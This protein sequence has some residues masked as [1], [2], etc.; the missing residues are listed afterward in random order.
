M[1]SVQSPPFPSPPQAGAVPPVRGPRRLRLSNLTPHRIAVERTDGGP[2]LVLPPFGCRTLEFREL[3]A[4]AVG[5]WTARGLAAVEPHHRARPAFGFAGLLLLGAVIT[6]PVAVL[7]RAYT[8]AYVWV[9]LVLLS[10]AVLLATRR[11]W[12]SVRDVGKQG[13]DWF[14]GTASLLVVCAVGFGL[15]LALLSRELEIDK[16]LAGKA[17][18]AV[19]L[20]LFIGVVSTVPALLYF[21]F[22]QQQVRALRERFF[23]EVIRLDP[24]LETLDDAR[25]LHGPLAD[26]TYGR[27][28]GA[29]LFRPS[30][31]PVLISTFLITL[32]WC[33][34]LSSAIKALHDNRSAAPA[35]AQATEQVDE[36]DQAQATDKDNQD[37]DQDTTGGTTFLNL[38]PTQAMPTFAFLGAYFFALN[39]LFRRY[40]RGDLG[41]KAYSHI[42]ARIV[43][44]VVLALVMSVVPLTPGQKPYGLIL[45]FLVGIFP[46]KGTPALQRVL[47]GWGPVGALF[48][49]RREEEDSLARLDGITQYDRSRLLEEGIENVENLAH[50]NLMELM[51]RTRIPTARLV[52]L[53][54]QAVLFLHVRDP[55]PAAPDAP[56]AAPS[57]LERLRALGIRTATDLEDALRTSKR[58]GEGGA[59]RALLADK[60]EVRRLELAAEVLRN[61]E[62]MPYLRHWRRW[63][64]GSDRTCTLRDFDGR[65]GE[66]SASSGPVRLQPPG[67][68]SGGP[69]LAAGN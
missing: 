19:V 40:A 44:A 34:V 63:K 32:G 65:A 46:E 9:A 13:W 31:V 7:A 57:R 27:T 26:Q 66:R 1:H 21:L 67:R 42:A 16:V 6:L 51:L 41:P 33:L 17:M 68:D 23:R 14:Q 15:P 4:L 11:A 2:P 38:R 39:M 29:S 45:A 35:T 69:R 10:A 30:G 62:W 56:G 8:P 43:I 22:D 37:K 25:A 49:S 55:E 53:V 3:S 5:E 61:D 50:H 24:A 58:A 12:G 20:V 48:P 52:D 36:Q 59:L 18:T 64:P 60:D 54:D 47:R 28:E